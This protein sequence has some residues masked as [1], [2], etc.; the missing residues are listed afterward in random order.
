MSAIAAVVVV[1]AC[2]SDGFGVRVQV[3]RVGKRD[4]IT[5]R[6]RIGQLGVEAHLGLSVAV[7]HELVQPVH[8]PDQNRAVIRMDAEQNVVTCVPVFDERVQLEKLTTTNVI[9]FISFNYL[10]VLTRLNKNSD[11]SN[12]VKCTK[13]V[14]FITYNME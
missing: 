11:K 14:T 4:G 9:L 5:D 6:Y 10:I 12:Q 13:S 3:D 2:C 8:Y 1:V 7:R